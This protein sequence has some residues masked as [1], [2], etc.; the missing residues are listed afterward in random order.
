MASAE[1][2]HSFDLS[3]GQVNKNGKDAI[4]PRFFIMREPNPKTGE[5][6]ETEYVELRNPGDR[7]NIRRPKVD[8]THKRRWPEHY[9]AFKLGLEP[10]EKGHALRTWGD[11]NELTMSEFSRLGFRSIEDL[12]QATDQAL[13]G[14]QGGFGWRKRAQVFLAAKAKEAEIDKDAIISD[15]QQKVEQLLKAQ[16]VSQVSNPSGGGD[17][18][19]RRPGRPPAQKGLETGRGNVPNGMGIVY[20]KSVPDAA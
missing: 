3:T 16:N 14:I 2:T 17:V 12:A 9:R 11:I 6:D 13:S 19:K 5:M 10:P 7:L 15:L 8:E 18:G 20:D 4:V 1:Y